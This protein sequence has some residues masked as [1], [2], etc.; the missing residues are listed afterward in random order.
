MK[1]RIAFSVVILSFPFLLS[2]AQTN[3][4]RIQIEAEKVPEAVKAAFMNSV[5][6]NDIKW[7][8][9]RMDNNQTRFVAVFEMMD[10]TSGK[11][12]ANRYR[13]TEAGKF[14]SSSQYRGSG[15]GG[16][17]LSVYLG[18]GGVEDAVLEKFKKLLKENQL[19]SLEGITFIPGN[20]NNAISGHRFVLAGNKKKVV[21]YMDSEMNEFDMAKYPVRL[22]EI[23][24]MD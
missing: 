23:A 15:A 9:M 8:K 1:T 12:L 3:S 18:T 10:P 21:R 24:E 20:Q 11:M 4:K 22:L 19:A 7:F 16:E 13:Y 2:I 5:G 14:T 17:D 6:W